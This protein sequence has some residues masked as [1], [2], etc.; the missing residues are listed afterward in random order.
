MAT[1]ISATSYRFNRRSQRAAVTNMLF[2]YKNCG[3][4]SK[5]LMT[6]TAAATVRL[7]IIDM[8]L[9]RAI[10]IVAGWVVCYARILC[11]CDYTFAHV[12]G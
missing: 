2:V 3:M 8:W 4:L 9:L 5:K 6:L 12:I 10:K 1:G 7:T 11:C